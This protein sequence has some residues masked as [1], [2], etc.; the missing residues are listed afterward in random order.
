MHSVKTIRAC[1]IALL[2]WTALQAQSIP[3]PRALIV[4]AA[5]LLDVKTG[6]YLSP[7]AILVEDQRVKAVDANLS[8]PS[9]ADVIDLGSATV[10]P[11]LVDCH[12][13][14]L[15]NYDPA[16]PSG[17]TNM[18]LTVAQ[19]STAKRALLGAEMAKEDLEAG[20]TTVRDLGNSGLNGDVALRERSIRGGSPA[21]GWS[22]LRVRSVLSEGSLDRSQVKPRSWWI[23]NI[24][25]SLERRRHEELSG[26][27]SSTVPI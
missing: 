14:L 18:I 22:F 16:L 17:T 23:R 27:H 5:H 11:G 4:R 24:Q 6:R 10:L 25:S 13:H 9:G 26:R 3:P 1:S 21:R 7:A 12:T 2:A 15:E 20:I 8:V 19:M